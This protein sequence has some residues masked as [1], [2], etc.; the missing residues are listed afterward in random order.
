MDSKIEQRVI[1]FLIDSG[2]KMAKIFLKLKKVFGNECALRACVFEWA[3]WF[4]EGR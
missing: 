3:R 4:E 1:K 2:E